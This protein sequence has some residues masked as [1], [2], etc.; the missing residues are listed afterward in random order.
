MEDEIEAPGEH[1][2]GRRVASHLS[3]S[4][5]GCCRTRYQT[6]YDTFKG[7][8]RDVGVGVPKAALGWLP[9]AAPA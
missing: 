4:S 3:P 6:P 5:G 2:R 7:T 1:R 9:P 8:L